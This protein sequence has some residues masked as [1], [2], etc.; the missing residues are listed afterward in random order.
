MFRFPSQGND[1]VEIG[2]TAV[3]SQRSSILRCARRL[4]DSQRT[5][6]VAV[7]LVLLFSLHSDAQDVGGVNSPGR[8]TLLPFSEF[9]DAESE[10]QFPTQP[11][12]AQGDSATERLPSPDLRPLRLDRPDLG[13]PRPNAAAQERASRYVVDR[14][15]PQLT[16][17]VQIGRPVILQFKQTPF[18]DQVADP[19]VVDALNVTETEYSINGKQLGSTV[20]NFWFQNPEASGGQEVLSYLVRVQEDPETARRFEVLLARIEREINRAFPNSVVR[21]S[22]VGSQVVVRGQAKGI[23]D[24]TQILRIVARSI[25]EEEGLDSPFSPDEF[26]LGNADAGA[27]IDSGGLTG[28]LDGDTASGVN[29]ARINGRVV[30]LLEIAGVHQVMLKVTIAEVNRSAVRRASANLIALFGDSAAFTSFGSLMRIAGGAFENPGGAGGTFVVDRGDFDLI[31]NFLKTHQLAKSLAEPTLT[32]LN[33]Q[34]ANFQVGG[35]FPVPDNGLNGEENVGGVN[36]V[37][38][39]S[40]RFVPFGVQLSFTPV[41]T[42]HDRIRLQLATSVS[43]RDEATGALIGDTEV[44]GLN[45]RQFTNVVELRE[46]QTLALAGLIQNNLGGDSD[47]VPFV[48]DIPYVGRLFSQDR[49]SQDEQELIVLVT[50]YLVNPVDATCQP[51]ALPGSDYFEPDDVEFFLRG[52]LT[53]H[54]AEDYR[55]SIRTDI[56]KMKAFRRLE[57]ELIIGQ[58]GH[59]NGL[60][61]PPVARPSD[62][63]L[64]MTP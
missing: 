51:L 35:S 27:I 53:G 36:F 44:S 14:V 43:T 25:P 32:T 11:V 16:L 59:S 26:F 31:L 46:G 12:L 7:C 15:D 30:N 34:R 57:Q 62:P 33:G 5:V 48:G 37:G 64:R 4:G 17:D 28:L 63:L 8:A 21:L 42:D 54:V 18:R 24:A 9:S 58:P 1:L 10:P 23:E 22:Y 40:V 13:T 38:G 45:E 49:T 2:G 61:C 56:Y 29:S 50:P 19:N 20:L 47:R 60:L 6:V 3:I 41:V 55:S 52:N 39:Q